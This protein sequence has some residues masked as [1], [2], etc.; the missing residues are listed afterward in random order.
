[1]RNG[2]ISIWIYIWLVFI[3]VWVIS[4]FT[5]KKTIYVNRANIPIRL[6]IIIMLLAGFYVIIHHH[7]L[8]ILIVHNQVVNLIG[9]IITAIGLGIAVWARIYLGSNWGVPMSIKENPE[10]ITSGPYKYVRHPIY[11]GILL[12]FIGSALVQGLFWFVIF[13]VFAIYF[14][15]AAGREEQQLMQQFP[16]QYPDY[17]KRTKSMIPL[18]W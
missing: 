7:L 8:P 14:I 10:L 4:A 12:A 17:K 6:M 1:M 2:Y 15:F 18:I 9:L 5:A 11:T 16:T 13:I 3:L